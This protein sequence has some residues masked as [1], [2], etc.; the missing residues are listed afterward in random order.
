M[1]AD[2]LRWAAHVLRRDAGEATPGPWHQH[3]F[4]HY[5]QDEP[6]SIVIHTG[7]FNHAGL[8]E[9]PAENGIAWMGW[10]AQ[11]SANAT[12]ITRMFPAVGLVF[13]DVL[14]RMA[15]RADEIEDTMASPKI[16]ASVI[17]HNIPGWDEASCA[18]DLI[19]G[20]VTS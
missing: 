11:E 1:I 19:L 15:N 17:A 18:A 5:G 12:Y 16:A 8:S 14:E 4:G 3:D 20:E 2:R 7:E 10:D 13:A 9:D 6:S